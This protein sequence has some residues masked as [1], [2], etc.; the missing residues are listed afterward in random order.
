MHKLFLPAHAYFTFQIQ[1]LVSETAPD[2]WV[3]VH[4]ILHFLP[5]EPGIV[6]FIWASEETGHL[7]LYLITCAVNGQ[8]AMI[9]DIMAEDESNAA[10]PRVISKEPLTDGDWEV[11]GRKIWVGHYI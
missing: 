11:M 8:R 2:A 3:N 10:V 4:D 1:V 6:R 7:H 9:T 5:S